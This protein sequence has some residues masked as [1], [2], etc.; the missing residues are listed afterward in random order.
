M[1]AVLVFMSWG[2]AE[3]GQMEL[4][5]Y[6][7]YSILGLLVFRIFWG[8]FGSDTARFSK[9]VRGP[10][11]IGDYLKSPAHAPK[12]IGHNPLGALS[13]V[14]MLLLLVTQVVL[15][16]FA[17]DIDGLESGPLSYL[18]TFDQGRVAAEAHEVVFNVLLGMIVLHVLAILYYWIAKRDNLIAP[19][20]TGNKQLPADAQ[21][22]GVSAPILKVLIGIAI[23]GATV[24]AII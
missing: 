19:M 20:I 2:S 22:S 11:A 14:A 18:V 13:V 4:H 21:A 5:R 15:G 16:L 3:Y 12:S 9:F 8:V 23:A 17:V 1:V 6:F 7:G 10:K 24:W